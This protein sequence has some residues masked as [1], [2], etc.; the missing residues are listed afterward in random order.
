MAYQT[1]IGL[2]LVIIR[3]QRVLLGFRTTPK[4]ANRMWH[5]PAGDLEEGESFLAGMAREAKE[6]LGIAISEGDLELIHTLHHRDADDGPGRI[7]LF[8]YPHKYK[9]D[10]VN[11][12]P[13]KC[14]ELRWV[15]LDDLP[16]DIVP[17]AVTALDGILAG[18]RVLVEGWS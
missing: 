15:R 9:G 16:E 1:V 14:D 7:Q 12:E 6:E 13:T 5:L 3:N 8:F 18:R 2:H 17:Y 11:N 10:I 4:W